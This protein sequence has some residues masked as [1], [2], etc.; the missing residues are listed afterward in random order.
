M[1]G[2]L[3]NAGITSTGVGSRSIWFKIDD[4]WCFFLSFLQHL[5]SI[6]SHF[7][8]PMRGGSRSGQTS[9][10]FSP[11]NLRTAPTAESIWNFKA[12]PQGC[13]WFVWQPRCFPKHTENLQYMNSG[14]ANKSPHAIA[15]TQSRPRESRR[16]ETVES[17]ESWKNW[18]SITDHHKRS[19]NCGFQF[20]KLSLFW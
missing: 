7:L 8:Q 17:V 10:F 4:D 11:S 13:A 16:V 15:A 2:M 5:Q 18:P 14:N 19:A 9:P 3:Q 20:C 6:Q 12:E 1:C